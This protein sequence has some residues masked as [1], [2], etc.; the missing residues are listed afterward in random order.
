M[1]FVFCTV[2]LFVLGACANQ[3]TLRSGIK[4]V[5]LDPS[6][7]EKES[8]RAMIQP[9]SDSLSA[10]MGEIIGRADT[11]FDLAYPNSNLMN[12]AADAL[13]QQETQAVKMREPVVVLLNAG[14]L[15]SSLNRGNITVGDLFKLMPF[16][17]VVA[18]VRLPVQCLPEIEKNLAQQ[19]KGV[20]LAN[21]RFEK[22]K[23][24]VQNLLPEHTH[25]TFIT[26]DYLVFGGD[27]M[28]FFMQPGSTEP[29]TITQRN[30]RDVLI[31]A[32]KQQGTLLNRTEKRYIP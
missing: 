6:Y 22:G 21:A 31:N 18:W 19:A 7:P 1:R 14:G 11:S 17:N 4:N 26:S 32:V 24:I 12:W 23:F 16:D 8:I 30:L 25:I 3:I 2:W 20:A 13:L 29:P 28:Q 27:N 9:F 10:Q 15:R 5:G